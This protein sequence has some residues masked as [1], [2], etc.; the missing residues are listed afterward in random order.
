MTQQQNSSLPL[1]EK[2]EK[3]GFY[4]INRTSRGRS[5]FLAGNLVVNKYA[6]LS[7]GAQGQNDPLALS[8]LKNRA[9]F[10]IGSRILKG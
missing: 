8:T 7:Y 10:T 6:T 5:H 4:H 9:L 2:L 1:I 3:A